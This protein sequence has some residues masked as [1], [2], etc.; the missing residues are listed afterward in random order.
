[1]EL[2]VT[3]ICS[4]Y[5]GVHVLSRRNDQVDILQIT[6]VVVLKY[7]SSEEDHIQKG[8]DMNIPRYLTCAVKS[9]PLDGIEAEQV[10]SSPS[11]EQRTMVSGDGGSDF[12][13]YSTPWW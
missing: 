4:L 12:C 11:G 13:Q 7:R 5:C 2:S 10:G 9:I 8:V 6:T 3:N 1:V